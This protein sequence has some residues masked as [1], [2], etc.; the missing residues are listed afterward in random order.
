MNFLRGTVEDSRGRMVGLIEPTRTSLDSN[1]RRALPPAI[2]QELFL[3]TLRR[4]VFVAVVIILVAGAMRI[5]VFHSISRMGILFTMPL[6]LAVGLVVPLLFYPLVN[7]NRLGALQ[8]RRD[9]RDAAI[10]NRLCATC[11][12]ALEQV[13]PGSDG[14]TACPECGS[15]WRL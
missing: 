15:A 1:R 2:R 9:V 3:R 4:S 10:R 7:S 14:L 8:W 5:L 11:L 13:P 6:P 12:Y